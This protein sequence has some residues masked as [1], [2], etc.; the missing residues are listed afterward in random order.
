MF[1]PYLGINFLAWIYAALLLIGTIV[2]W[3]IDYFFGAYVVPPEILL[4]RNVLYV[5][6]IPFLLVTHFSLIPR[7]FAFLLRH[8]LVVAV[9]ILICLGL[10]FHTELLV[11]ASLAIYGSDAVA[12][13]H[14]MVHPGLFI[15]LCAVGGAAVYALGVIALRVSQGKNKQLNRWV[16]MV[17]VPALYPVYMLGVPGVLSL[18]KPVMSSVSLPHVIL[19]FVCGVGL[20][21]N[22]LWFERTQDLQRRKAL[23]SFLVVL[24]IAYALW[25]LNP[26]QC[27][28]VAPCSVCYKLLLCRH[29]V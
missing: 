3:M 19:C 21:V 25:I 8:L 4:A 18:L 13:Q 7:L 12:V 28:L 26:L 27:E 24:C 6:F 17:Q 29:L 22:F 1:Y 9:A 5:L 23:G 2:L 14:Y 10:L 20:I 11:V 15:I 16:K